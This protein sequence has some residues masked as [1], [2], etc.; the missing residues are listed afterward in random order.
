MNDQ[1]QDSPMVKCLR[2]DGTKYWI[3]PR[4]RDASAPRP[5]GGYRRPLSKSL[6]YACNGTGKVPASAVQR[7]P[8]SLED[9]QHVFQR[10]IS[11]AMKLGYCKTA[12]VPLARMVRDD[13]RE[14]VETGQE[15]RQAE[16][17]ARA[18]YLL[19]LSALLRP[20]APYMQ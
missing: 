20:A 10:A 13:Y 3:P 4:Q 15:V 8:C 12:A 7:I 16:A 18:K 14:A 9:R 2:C 6:C 5:G 11:G 17:D 1:V 19:P